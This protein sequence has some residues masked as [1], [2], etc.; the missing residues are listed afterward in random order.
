[1]RTNT[2]TDVLNL[3]QGL[4]A[5]QVR[6]F[7]SRIIPELRRLR[8]EILQTVPADLPEAIKQSTQRS[9]NGKMPGE[10]KDRQTV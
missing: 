5:P 3:F 6:E 4:T 9:E 7:R 1:M 10:N 8:S 2:N